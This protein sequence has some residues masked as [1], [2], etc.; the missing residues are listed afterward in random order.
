MPPRIA[1]AFTFPYIRRMTSRA[2]TFWTILISGTIAILLPMTIVTILRRAMGKM[3]TEDNASI[4]FSEFQA[5]LHQ[6]NIVHDPV[7]AASVAN[8]AYRNKTNNVLIDGWGKPMNIYAVMHGNS[9][10]LDIQSAGPDGNFGDSDDL[11]LRQTFDL[12]PSKP[13]TTQSVGATSQ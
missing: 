1:P 6:G 2:K 9:C 5:A 3:I 8:E 4:V 12:S 11:T 7:A 10:E 13:S